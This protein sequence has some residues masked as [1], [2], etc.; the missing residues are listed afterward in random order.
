MK[1]ILI[2]G[3]TGLIGKQLSKKLQEKGYNVALL[4]RRPVKDSGFRVYTWNPDSGVIDPEAISMADYIIH[5]AGAGLGDSRWTEKRKKE[6][7]DSRIKT[8]GLI[9]DKLKE[10]G[11]RPEA[12]I[13][14]S[15]SGYYGAIT[16]ETIHV[17]TDDP[18]ADFIGEVCRRWEEAAGKIESLGIRTVILR[19]GIVLSKSGGALQRMALPAK[20]GIGS[21]LGSGRQYV[22]WIHIDDLCGIYIKAIEDQSMTGAYNSAAPEHVSNSRFMVTVSKV[23][24]RPFFFPAIPSFA[25]RILFGEMSSILLKGSRVSSEKIIS[26]GYSFK[27]PDLRSALKSLL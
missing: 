18:A 5:L 17:E 19:T 24:G 20:L 8:A 23:M 10:S 14:A 21:P 2:T 16:S 3:G 7:L 11:K 15:G 4:S 9:L 6:I 13:S 22:P 27:Y 12:F 26:S 25:F 1:N